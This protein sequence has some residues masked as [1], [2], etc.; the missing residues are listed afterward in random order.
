[1]NKV[2]KYILDG[3]IPYAEFSQHKDLVAFTV[4]ADYF[5]Y[6]CETGMDIKADFS[7]IVVVVEKEW[8]FFNM[9]NEGIENPL[10]YLQ[11]EYTWDDSV[12]WFESAKLVGK[13]VAIQFD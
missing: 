2:R 10:Q 4:G 11:D 8:L 9:T 13:I 3:M 7:E 5:T 6:D 12:E 1:M